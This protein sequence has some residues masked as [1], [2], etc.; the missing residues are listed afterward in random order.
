MPKPKPDVLTP[1]IAFAWLQDLPPMEIKN[2][3]LDYLRWQAEHG[4]RLL[5]SAHYFRIVKYGAVPR[6]STVARREAQTKKVLGGLTNGI[7][8]P[9]PEPRRK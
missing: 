1:A 8:Q 3:L 9:L 6:A 2:R 5:H 4:K 7:G